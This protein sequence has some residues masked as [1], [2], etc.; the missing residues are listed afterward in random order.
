[1]GLNDMSTAKSPIVVTETTQPSPPRSF[2][3]TLS[4]SRDEYHVLSHREKYPCAQIHPPLLV[5]YVLT[6]YQNRLVFLVSLAATF[7]PLASN[8]YFPALDQIAEDVAAGHRVVAL[9]ITTYL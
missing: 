9:T 1:M 5:F 8:I 3:S 6:V 4:P 2:Q 7:S